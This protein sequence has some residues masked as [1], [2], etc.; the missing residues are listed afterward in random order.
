MLNDSSVSSTPGDGYASDIADVTGMSGDT[1]VLQLSVD[2]T[3]AASLLGGVGNARLDWLNTNT[4]IWENAVNSDTGG[5]AQ[6][7]NGAYTP[8][9]D[10]QLGYYGVNTSNDTVWAVVNGT[11]DFAVSDVNFVEAPEP[12]TR[13]M[14]LMGAAGLGLFRRRDNK[15]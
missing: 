9:T 12:G 6:F 13:T 2:P 5:I 3:A 14:L 8:G 7:V 1:Y 4:D 10:F 15:S 11:G